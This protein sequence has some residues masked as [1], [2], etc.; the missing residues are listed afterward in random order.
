MSEAEKQA[1]FWGNVRKIEGG[2]WEWEGFKSL[3]YGRFYYEGITVGAHRQAY[4]WLREPIPKGLTI[5]HLCRNRACVNPEHLE[6]V[7]LKENVLRGEGLTAMHL[8]ATHCPQ[9][10]P[11]DS[12]NTYRTPRGWRDCKICRKGAKKR[13]EERSKVAREVAIIRGL[14]PWESLPDKKVEKQFGRTIINGY[15][16]KEGCFEYADRIIALFPDV[17]RIEELEAQIKQCLMVI[18]DLKSNLVSQEEAVKAEGERIIN[19]A[20]SRIEGLQRLLACYRLGKNPTEKL[21]SLL[22]KSEKDW[23]ALKKES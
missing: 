5:D 9:G 7:T 23:L 16:S 4:E 11:Y 6:V 12:V 22:E 18:K 1:R 8:R 10:H 3:G 14:A 2:C 20:D 19:V 13:W 15:A 21:F 17:R